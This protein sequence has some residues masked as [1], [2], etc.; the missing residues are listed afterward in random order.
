MPTI[1]GTAALFPFAGGHVPGSP[2]TT[3]S[4][5]GWFPPSASGLHRPHPW[6]VASGTCGLRHLA[7]CPPVRPGSRPPPPGSPRPATALES[8]LQPSRSQRSHPT[9]PSI[10]NGPAPRLPSPPPSPSQPRA[11]PSEHPPG[12]TPAVSRRELTGGEGGG[13]GGGRRARP[14]RCCNGFLHVTA[15]FPGLSRCA[16]PALPG[17]KMADRKRRRQ[18]GAPGDVIAA[19]GG[20]DL[21]A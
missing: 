5:H 17:T 3:P 16:K 6:P 20:S 21:V 1:G 12:D 7:A 15:A 19:R 10:L 18:R 2:R 13:G 4:G 11:T 14:Q 9:A 8:L